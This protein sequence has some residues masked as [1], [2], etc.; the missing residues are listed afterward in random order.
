MAFPESPVR[1]DNFAVNLT[2][3]VTL[4]I[5]DSPFV[6]ELTSRVLAGFGIRRRRACQT[7]EAAMSALATQSVDLVLV[8][9]DLPDSSGYELVHWLRRSAHEANQFVPV[10]MT[11]THV[12]P[13]T[14][15][16]ARDSGASLILTK[17]FS[18]AKL[19]ERIVWAARDTRPFLEAGPY[20]GPDRR[21]RKLGYGGPERRVGT[22][23]IIARP[24]DPLG[25][26]K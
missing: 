4:V 9:A 25:L 21:I 18:P 19:L 16:R 1:A 12:L 8:S 24:G 26:L 15:V 10:I 6:L 3:A 20:R 17:P 23:P 22:V 14:L 7:P 11:A 13:S 5:E 2:E